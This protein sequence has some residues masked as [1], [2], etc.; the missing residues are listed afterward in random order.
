[1]VSH[2][3]DGQDPRADHLSF[4]GNERRHDKTGAVTEA[5]VWFHV[6]GLLREETQHRLTASVK[7]KVAK[8][9]KEEVK[10]PESALCDQEWQ[11]QKPS[12]S[13]R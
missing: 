7:G 5:Q 3:V 8:I 10:V 9:F 6:Q 2:L 1:M 13:S 12:Y 4:S 11:R